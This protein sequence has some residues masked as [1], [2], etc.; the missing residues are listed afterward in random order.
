MSRLDMDV[1]ELIAL[2]NRH[3]RVDILQLDGVGGHC[4]AVDPWSIV[5]SA[6]QTAKLIRSGRVV[7]DAKPHWVVSRLWKRLIGGHVTV[8]NRANQLAFMV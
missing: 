5:A 3:P 7:N 1:W 4:M 6:P 8:R 2:A